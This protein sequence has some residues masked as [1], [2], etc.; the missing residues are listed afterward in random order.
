MFV[1]ESLK[2]R[3]VGSS[4]CTY[5]YL[6]IVLYFK[7]NSCIKQV[8]YIA[9][10]GTRRG[11]AALVM[12]CIN[13]YVN[14]NYCVDWKYGLINSFLTKKPRCRYPFFVSVINAKKRINTRS[15]GSS[16]IYK[17]KNDKWQHAGSSEI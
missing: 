16:K 14:K 9:L 15:S 5:F 1:I 17:T 3:H 2:N 6:F 8:T 4:A 11:T 12:Q 7:M 10:K 13:Y